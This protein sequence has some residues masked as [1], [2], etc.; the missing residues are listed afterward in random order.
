MAT[1]KRESKREDF[2]IHF[3]S[4]M[5][6]YRRTEMFIM[7]ETRIAWSEIPD[8]IN[9]AVTRHLNS[10]ERDEMEAR[11]QAENPAPLGPAVFVDFLNSLRDA[12]PNPETA[13]VYTNASHIIEHA[14]GD[15][16]LITVEC[17]VRPE[18]IG[19]GLR[20]S[21]SDYEKAKKDWPRWSKD[22]IERCREAMAAIVENH[23]VNRKQKRQ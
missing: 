1:L 15:L 22:K 6:Y 18:K 9:R 23:E 2:V 11:Y 16:M 5:R 10:E 17:V 19:F 7:D 3:A 14:T 4:G 20:I 12:A 13:S 21:Q 8:P